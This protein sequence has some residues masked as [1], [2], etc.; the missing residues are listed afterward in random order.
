MMQ[1]KQIP[2]TRR[3]FSKWLA[4]AAGAAAAP[5]AAT[6]ALASSDDDGALLQLQEQVFEAWEAWHAH[7]DE[8]YGPCGLDKLRR[9]EYDR[10]LEQEKERGSYISSRERWDVVF[11]NPEVQRLDQLVVLSEQ[12]FER[13]AALVEQMW[14]IPAKTEAGRSAKVE[15]LLTCVMDWRDPDEAM[16]WRPLMARRLLIDL[17]GGKEAES[18]REIYA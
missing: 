7:D 17:V 8:I 11:Q 15:V 13:M 3:Q 9:A 1:A 2:T 12:H 10:L 18:F 4:A 5:L 14:S 6:S 16:D